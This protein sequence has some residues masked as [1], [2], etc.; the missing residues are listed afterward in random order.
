MQSNFPGSRILSDSSDG[1]REIRE[2]L[3]TGHPKG[4]KG[5]KNDTDD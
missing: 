5:Y 4:L 2:I 3:E 1:E